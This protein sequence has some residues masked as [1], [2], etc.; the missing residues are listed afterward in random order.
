MGI[1]VLLFVVLII[2]MLSRAQSI[3][4]EK[5]ERLREI[6]GNL[7][8]KFMWNGTI[9][10]IN[11]SFLPTCMTFYSTVRTIQ[12]SEGGST[13]EYITSVFLGLFIL[14]TLLI[15]FKTLYKNRKSLRSKMLTD[16]IGHLYKGIQIRR[17]V[18]LFAFIY[19]PISLC[20]RFLFVLIPLCFYDSGRQI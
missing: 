8:K 4:D 15:Y 10:S 13:T 7:K 20:R 12:I 1:F 19:W 9:D 3:S 14:G 11:V 18:T 16:R 2:W 5:K 17:R 6:L